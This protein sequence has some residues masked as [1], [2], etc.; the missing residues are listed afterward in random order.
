MPPRSVAGQ[1]ARA[2]DAPA[3]GGPPLPELAGRLGYLLKHAQLAL[4]ELNAAA[5]APSGISGRQLA[6]LIAVDSSAPLSQAE[7]AGRLGVDRTTMV[8][9]IDELEDIGLVRRQRDP[10]DRRKNVVVLT[11][12]GRQTL[13]AAKEASDAAERQFLSPLPPAQAAALRAA[14]RAVAFPDQSES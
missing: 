11:G 3:A 10:A 14:L 12:D 6:V 5:L 8:A 7:A 1:P 13:A 2:L 4:A 9:L